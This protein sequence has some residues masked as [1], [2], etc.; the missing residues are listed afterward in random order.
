MTISKGTMRAVFAGLLVHAG[1]LVAVSV[2]RLNTG[3]PLQLLDFSSFF[4]AADSVFN[5][6]QSPYAADLADAYG[7]RFDFKVYPFVYPPSALP[8]FL[9]FA[10]LGYDSGAAVMLAANCAA[11]AYLT[12]KLAD[13]LIGPI[14]SRRIVI[15]CLA[16]LVVFDPITR[17]FWNGQ[18]NLFV[19][20]LILLAWDRANQGRSLWAGVFLGLA[21]VLKTYPAVLFLVFLVRRD[22]RAIAAGAA[23]VGG[24][25]ALSLLALPVEYWREWLFAV[26][27]TA[28]YTDTPFEL[29][30]SGHPKNQSF[31]GLFSRL[32]ADAGLAKGLAYSASA[33][34]LAASAW[35][36]VRLRQLD[37]ARYHGIGFSVLILAT[38]FIAPWS[39]LHH[40]VFTLPA[41]IF[42]LAY[43][44][45]PENRFAVPV[46]R[47]AVA[48]ACLNAV[49]W[50]LTVTEIEYVNNLPIVPALGMWLMLVVLPMLRQRRLTAGMP[51]PA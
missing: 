45:D 33:L 39:W 36:L 4:Y 16:I 15:L 1:W 50:R 38:I 47:I 5:L 34:I 3:A 30:F 42:L 25:I 10:F 28:D 6:G 22:I 2:F 23:T 20:I 32:A 31:N 48:L 35:C 19:A 44:F 12:I 26:A 41:M 18:I 7:A 27:P 9:P 11:F 24:F 46:R 51:A 29:V 8:V 40:Y 17:T 43:A 21:V 37:P 49:P 14:P 13:M